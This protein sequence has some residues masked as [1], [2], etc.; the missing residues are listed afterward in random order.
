MIKVDVL[1]VGGGPAGAACAWRL[2]QGGANCLILDRSSFPRPKP[3]AGWITPGVL[4][5]LDFAIADYPCSFTTFSSF[6]VAIKNF[7]FKLRTRQYAIRRIE[8]DEWLLRRAGAPFEVHEVKSIR[9]TG[10]GYEIDGKYFA[11]RLIGA[12]GTH[13]PVY[14]TLFKPAHPKPRESLI[15][16]MEEEFHYPQADP[17]CR[18]WFFQ[19][20]LPGYAWYVPKAGGW[21]NIGIGGTADGMRGSNNRLIDHWGRL[22]QRLAQ[23]GLVRGH[24]FQPS[25]Y[26]YYLRQRK[27]HLRQGN[28]FLVGDAAGLATRD[29]GEGIAAAVRSGILAAEAILYGREYSVRAVPRYSWVS[30][31][32]FA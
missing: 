2:R 3:C 19:D 20:G 11:R 25:A 32:P 1:I 23:S 10:D 22:V 14:Q 13:C 18:L 31:N 30:M 16:A 12:G 26:T 7:R 4:D 15:V 6:Q 9:Q 5:D 27:P 17:A 29:M 24:V 21:L 28:A 8:F